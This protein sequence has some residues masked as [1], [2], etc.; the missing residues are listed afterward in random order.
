[1]QDTM[2]LDRRTKDL[3]RDYVPDGDVL[4][5]IVCFFSRFIKGFGY[6]P[7]YGFTSVKIA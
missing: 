2:L 1:M 7:N 5:S 3:V 6:K 4:D